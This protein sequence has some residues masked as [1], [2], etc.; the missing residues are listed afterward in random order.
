MICLTC[1]HYTHPDSEMERVQ[2]STSCDCPCHPWNQAAARTVS[3]IDE[4]EVPIE[5]EWL[6]D[7]E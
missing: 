1:N 6:E 4:I 5:I 7:D 3:P 2:G